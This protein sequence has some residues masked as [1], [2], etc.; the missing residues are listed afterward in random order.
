[1]EHADN[2]QTAIAELLNEVAPLERL[3]TIAAAKIAMTMPLDDAARALNR[4][5]AGNAEIYTHTGVYIRIPKDAA[6]DVV[7]AILAISICALN[8][9]GVD[10]SASCGKWHIEP[11]G[12]RRMLEAKVLERSRKRVENR[13]KNAM[14]G[15]FQQEEEAK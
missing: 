14:H 8:G 2:L 5:G 1:M 6:L 4:I 15:T 9:E 11:A 12:L 7:R 3:E 10:I 13:I